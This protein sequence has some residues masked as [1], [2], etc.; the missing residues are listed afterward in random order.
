MAGWAVCLLPSRPRHPHPPQCVLPSLH[1]KWQDLL[2]GLKSGDLHGSL[3]SEL[4]RC[5]FCLLGQLAAG[6]LSA[7]N[8][9]S[10][11]HVAG[12]PLACLAVSSLFPAS[13]GT[14]RRRTEGPRGGRRY[15]R[16]L[17]QCREGGGAVWPLFHPTLSESLQS[18]VPRLNLPSPQSREAA[19]GSLLFFLASLP[20][21]TFQSLCCVSPTGSVS[22]IVCV[23]H[24]PFPRLPLPV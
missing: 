24:L 4:S 23:C 6:L 2:Q 15:P 13:S 10:T 17:P 8:D 21:P 1:L 11:G 16:A 5:V 14:V 18:V 22:S 12:P 19:L 7:F 9:P 20:S 3:A